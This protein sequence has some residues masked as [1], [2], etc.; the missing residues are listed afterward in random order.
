MAG[1]AKAVIDWMLGDGR[2]IRRLRDFGGAMCERLTAAGFPIARVLCGVMT[3]HPLTRAS[4]YIWRRDV[5]IEPF[6]ATHAATATAGFR[7]SAPYHV[8]KTG[9]PVRR[10]LEDPNCPIDF[11]ILADFRAAGGT[12]YLALP[13]A[14]SDGTWNVLSLLCDRPAGFDDVDVAG[15]TEIARVLAPIVE[16]QSAQHIAKTLLDTYVGRRSGARVLSG[17]I[18]RGAVESLEAVILCA[19]LRRFTVLSDNLPRE[20][21]LALLND[22]FELLSASVTA[23][24]GEI[25]KFIGDGLLAIFPAETATMPAQARAA[26]AAAESAIA[27]IRTR[28]R[29]REAV[30]EPAI[31]FAIALHLGEVGYGNIGAPDRLDF[32]VIGPAV[33]HASRLEEL[34]A[35]LKL[36]LVTSAAF[37]TMVGGDALINLGRHDLRGVAEPQQVF[38][39]A[40]DTTKAAL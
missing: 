39:L 36:R 35:K 3:L 28:N 14:C 19:D 15:L 9:Q 25:L 29:A 20:T 30:G 6:D 13:M 8:Y 4:A 5:G 23:A 17:A 1:D 32:T 21:V 31:R 34:A 38:G 18:T 11:T 16:L 27:T 22:W 24:G 37:A 33:N 7:Q 26:L 2:R 10:R 40:G 12:D